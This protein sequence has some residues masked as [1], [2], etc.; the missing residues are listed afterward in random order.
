MHELSQLNIMI[1]R[2]SPEGEILCHKVQEMGAS[3]IFFPAIEIIP[4]TESPEFTQIISNLNNLDW[5]I[6]ISPQAVRQT[7][8]FIHKQWPAFPEHVRIAALGYGT[9]QALQAAHLPAAI[10][11]EHQWNSEGLL[12]LSNFQN[13][14]QQKIALVRGEGGRTL[15]AEELTRRGAKLFHMITYKRGLPKINIHPYLRLLKEKKVDVI[16]TSSSEILQ[17]ITQL[18]REAESAL[19]SVPLIVISGKMVELAKNMGFQVIFLA[20]NASHEAIMAVLKEHVCQMK[21]KKM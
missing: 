14:F 13:I 12:A 11:P 3:P 20:K 5:L 18:L 1:T 9:A 21:L 6:F 7:A 4:L 10:Y 2:P 16:I 15:L 17:N 8:S 19:Y